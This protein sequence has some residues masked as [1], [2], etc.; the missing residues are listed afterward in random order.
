MPVGTW[1]ETPVYRPRDIIFLRLGKKEDTMRIVHVIFLAIVSAASATFASDLQKSVGPYASIDPSQVR[2]G[3]E[4][5]RRIDL[6][7]QKNLLALNVDNDFIKPFRDKKLQLFGYIGVGKLI[8][9]TVSFA[10]YSKDPK[11]LALKKDLTAKLLGTQLADGYIGA[12][13]AGARLRD[14]FD[15]HEIGYIIHALVDDYRRFRDQA[16]LQAAQRLGDYVVKNYKTAVASRNPKLIC[17]IDVE[18]SL[19]LLSEASRNPRY[20]D[21]ILERDGLARWSAPLDLVNAAELSSADGH[22]YTF[23]NRCLAQMDLY[24]EQPNEKLLGQTRRLVDYLIKNDGLMISGTSGYWERFRNNHETRGDVGET[25]A[26]AYLIRWLHEWLQLQGETLCGDIMERSI[27]NALF[28]AQSPDGRRLRYFTAIDGPR[29]YYD[30]DTYCCPGNW[31]RIVAELPEMVYYRSADGGVLVNLY[32]HS[33]ATVPIA[34]GLSV[35]MRQETD[36]PNSGKVTIVVKPSRSSDFPVKLRIPR[37]CE[38]A[39]VTING[40]PANSPTKPGEWCSIKRMWKA[41]DVVTLEMPMKTRLVRGRQLQAG[42][43]AVMRGPVLFCLSPS[44]QK[45][46]YPEYAGH[47]ANAAEIQRSITE[48]LA[49]TKIDWTTLGTPISDATLRPDGLALEVRG[50]GPKDDRSKPANRQFVLT[51]FTDP[52]GELTYFPVDNHQTGVDDELYSQPP[53]KTRSN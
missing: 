41:G 48:A 19:L 28:A 50:W 20:R 21:Y 17:T 7:I 36:Y 13:P 52:T 8:D 23:M 4:M 6:A 44:R 12:F 25:C 40:Q 31:R 14:V 9:A 2:L 24:R 32:A 22:A 46:R 38:S 29:K 33:T 45:P 51:E 37:W 30:Q 42:K 39:A 27:Y 49:N 1:P 10:Y 18:R 43:V 47:G 53:A 11:V 15:E 3:G 16:S 26:T 35:E 5:G 34:N